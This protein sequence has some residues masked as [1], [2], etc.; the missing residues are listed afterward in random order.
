MKQLRSVLE[1]ILVT[2]MGSERRLVLPLEVE[3]AP[4]Q[5]AEVLGFQ[6]QILLEVLETG[7]HLGGH[8]GYPAA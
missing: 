7:G 2:S 4:V 5:K 6:T 3:A 8:L 1:W